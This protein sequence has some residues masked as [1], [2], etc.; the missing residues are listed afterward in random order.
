MPDM[1][2]AGMVLH[3]HHRLLRLR[4]TPLISFTITVFVFVIIAATFVCEVLRALMFMCAA[5]VLEAAHDLVDVGGRVFVQLLIMAKDH[6][7][8][9][10]GAEDGELVRL[11]EQA[12][13][14]LEEGD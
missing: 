13:F 7:R 14:A 11:L 3:A 6:N 10:D 9:V 12:A 5:I 2:K 1:L 8:D 4:C